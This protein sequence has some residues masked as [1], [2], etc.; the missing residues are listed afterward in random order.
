M[1]EYGALGDATCDKERG[2]G[3]G[4]TTLSFT[5]SRAANA[6]V[7]PAAPLEQRQLH[8]GPL[9]HRDGR[10]RHG[11]VGSSRENTRDSDLLPVC[12]DLTDIH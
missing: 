8:G 1:S 5:L 11:A 7:V 6:A 9:Q 4:A 3:G 10:Q 12:M 2:G